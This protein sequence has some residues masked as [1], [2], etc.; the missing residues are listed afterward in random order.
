V[1]L[2]F[3]SVFLY[4]AACAAVSA[5]SNTFGIDH[6][7]SDEIVTSYAFDSG[8]VISKI[9][10][11][12]LLTGPLLNQ[13]I[14]K[15]ISIE[16]K[17]LCANSG[18]QLKLK[19][20]Y[21]ANLIQ[22]DGFLLN[23]A[24]WVGL[25]Q[26]GPHLEVYNEGSASIRNSYSLAWCQFSN[27]IYGDDFSGGELQLKSKLIHEFSILQFCELGVDTDT[28]GQEYKA[29]RSSFVKSY[30]A[31]GAFSELSDLKC[32][33][34]SECSNTYT[35]DVLADIGDESK[36]SKADSSV[37]ISLLNRNIASAPEY[38]F[39]SWATNRGLFQLLIDGY[40]TSIFVEANNLAALKKQNAA[41]A[42]KKEAEAAEARRKEKIR[43]QKEID[44]ITRRALKQLF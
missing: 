40:K 5:D 33:G 7:F 26:C 4:L 43:R 12:G 31:M 11:P 14:D 3:F 24:S 42:R 34:I 21:S 44:R 38:F 9:S 8:P 27:G 13:T 36:F 41:A 2:Y 32:K 20:L 19:D 16:K 22:T 1:R 37:G 29:A 35:S 23:L 18:D 15:Y 28:S 10:N 17:R 39:D 30:L 25:G 6:S